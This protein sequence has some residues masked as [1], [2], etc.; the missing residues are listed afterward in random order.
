MTRHIGRYQAHTNIALIKY[1][2]KRNEDLILPVTNS[3]SLTLQAFYAQTQ[4]EFS[5]SLAHDQFILNG[6]V[7]DEKSL[8]KISHFLDRFRVLAECDSPAQVISNNFVPTA[9]GLASSSSAFA[10]LACACNQALGLDLNQRQLSILARQGSGSA[11]RSL[12]GGLVEWE[13]GEKNLSDTSYAKPID[14]A[15]W[16]LAMLI[17]LV[18]RGEKKISSRQGMRLT[19]ATS[20][21]YAF[22]PQ[23]VAEDLAAMKEAIGDRDLNRMGQIMEHNAMKMHATMLASNP[24]FTYLEGDSIRAINAVKEARQAGFI[25]YYTM[26]A[27]P[28]VK[29]LCPEAQ[30]KELIT[31]MRGRLDDL[32]IIH[33]GVGPSPFPIDHL[34]VI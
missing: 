24:S 11:S 2:G 4:V 23:T 20:P 26:D 22:W 19:M 9:A 15:D 33:S 28:N 30:A 31:F 17:I 6:K 29:I 5:E 3:L 14:P 32:Q 1:W 18:N 16:G 34:D 13:R 12:Y 27:G 10:A 21:F 7:Q 8:E 25:A